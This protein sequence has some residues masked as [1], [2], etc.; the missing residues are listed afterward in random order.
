[1]T[2]YRRLLAL[3]LL[4]IENMG[5]ISMAC[6]E[7][8]I[9]EKA[10]NRY[11]FIYHHFQGKIKQDTFGK[12]F[13][14]SADRGSLQT[15]SVFTV[16]QWMGSFSLAYD[17]ILLLS[18]RIWLWNGWWKESDEGYYVWTGKPRDNHSFIAESRWSRWKCNRLKRWWYCYSMLPIDDRWWSLDDR[19]CRYTICQSIAWMGYS[20][21]FPESVGVE[22]FKR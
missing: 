19:R 3:I 22:G 6:C 12:Q 21:T 11:L 14:G 10:S 15:V 9:K 8:G 17:V 7:H 20:E 18:S 2:G 13:D 4:T 5:T 1:M 16:S